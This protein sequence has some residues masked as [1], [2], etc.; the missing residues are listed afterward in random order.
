MKRRVS[1]PIQNIMSI[2]IKK[3]IKF[4]DLIHPKELLTIAD[5]KKHY[6]SY[7]NK[8]SERSPPD[9]I[10]RYEECIVWYDVG[11]VMFLLYINQKY[12]EFTFFNKYIFLNPYASHLEWLEQLDLNMD[13]KENPKFLLFVQDGSFVF[14]KNI[15]QKNVSKI[16]IIMVSHS[17]TGFTGHMGCLFIFEQKGYYYDSNGLKDL[18]VKDYYHKFEKQLASVL[19]DYEIQYCPYT[20]KRGIQSI[21]DSEEEKYKLKIPGMCCAWSYLIIELKLLNPQLTVEMIEQKIKKKYRNRLT[22]YIVT[23]HQRLHPILF[24]LSKTIFTN[25]S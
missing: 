20:W 10:K 5:I 11:A 3:N 6:A 14:D 21:Q 22:R 19:L 12:P 15:I 4:N 13:E 7:K 23:Y 16:Q 1:E 8:D 18:D 17:F 25:L 2:P 24:D 9:S